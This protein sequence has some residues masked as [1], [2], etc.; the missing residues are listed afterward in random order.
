MKRVTEQ[1][2]PTGAL[3]CASWLHAFTKVGVLEGGTAFIISVKQVHLAVLDYGHGG[4]TILYRD[5]GK[6]QSTRPH[7]LEQHHCDNQECPKCI[8]RKISDKCTDY[9][10]D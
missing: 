1:N 5:V 10:F 7:I 6:C 8:R 4:T 3:D 2:I 9:G